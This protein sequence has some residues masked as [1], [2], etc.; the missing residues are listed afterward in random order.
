ML[1][2][3]IIEKCQVWE[4]FVLSQLNTL[5]VQSVS[6]AQ[7]YKALKENSW[8]VGVYDNE[9]LIGGSLVLSTHAKRGNFLFLPYGPVFGVE[10][11]TEQILSALTDYLVGLAKKNQYDFIRI[12]P[13]LANNEFNKK[14][15]LKLNYRQAPIHILAETTWILDLN[16]TEEEI[17]NKMNKNHRNLIR[18]CL[19]ESVVI[20]QN[21][22]EQ[23]TI[24]FNQLHDTTAERHN[25]HRFSNKYITEEFTTFAKNK[26][27]V[28]FNAYLSDGQLDSSAIIIYYGQMAV[29]RHGASLNLNN[30]IPTSYLIQWEAIKEAK[31]RGMK[32][33]NFWGIA[34]EN[35]SSNHPFKGITH[36]KK[37]FGGRQLD[38]LPCQDLPITKKYWLNWIIETIRRKK[39][40]F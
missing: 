15:F 17:L 38:L 26:E 3:E 32:Y 25:F 18:R 2:V 21:Q 4:N 8:L 29:Y 37:G 9:T 36:F 39:R 34:P 14:L 11:K 31:K 13:F 24:K 16:Q 33:Y 19:K 40:G 12:S 23:A 5:F 1:K 27:A 30:K 20:E 6:Y 35:A 7:F 28:V 22:N 10:N